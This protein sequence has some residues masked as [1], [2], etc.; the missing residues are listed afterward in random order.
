MAVYDCC[1]INSEIDLLKM[2]MEILEPYVDFFVVSEINKTFRGNDKEYQLFPR[3]D[4]FKNYKDKIVYVNSNCVPKWDGPGDWSIEAHQ[5]NCIA[6]GL[7]SCKAND[8]VMISDV[9]EIPDP[10]ILRSPEKYY[11]HGKWDSTLRNNKKCLMKVA[12]SLGLKSALLLSIGKLNLQNALEK[13]PV[14]IRMKNHYY[15]MNCKSNGWIPGTV[16]CK[17]KNLPFPQVA[18]TTRYDMPYLY[19][20]GWHFSYL[21]GLDSIKKKLNTILDDRPDIIDKMQRYSSQDEY[22]L[23][24]LRTGKDLYGRNDK[25]NSF[26]FIE[27][28]DIGLPDVEKYMKTYPQFFANDI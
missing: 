20:A 11:L 9:D 16:I 23:E 21:G 17:Y 1:I 15:Y 7:I 22:I 19:D 6:K 2:R 24:C 28:K 5:R 18:R 27:I 8:L 25:A 4:E 10:D 14:V 13:T 12:A 26:R 3:L